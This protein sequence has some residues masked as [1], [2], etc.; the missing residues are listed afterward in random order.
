MIRGQVATLNADA[1]KVCAGP[2]HRDRFR[3]HA[4]ATV[5]GSVVAWRG[6]KNDS[7]ELGE[8]LASETKCGLEALE[9]KLA[10]VQRPSELVERRSLVLAY[11]VARSLQQDDV[12]RAPQT[13]REAHVPFAL[14]S[15]K[16][17]ERENHGLPRLQPFVSGGGEQL[18]G[19]LLDL[20]FRD[21][22]GEQRPHP[23]RGERGAS[24]LD[25]SFGKPGRRRCLGADDDK[26]AP[27]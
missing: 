27:W 23:S 14:A 24:L 12:S 19:A 9:T 20:R 4:L 3:V 15:V 10:G 25:D 6:L 18:A 22:T 8:R 2:G 5:G 21:P 16:A 1:A 13:M 26:K 7:L 17:L 11:R